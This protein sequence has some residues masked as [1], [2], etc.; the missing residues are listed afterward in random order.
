MPVQ[1]LRISTQPWENYCGGLDH[2]EIVGLVQEFE[3]I[4]CKNGID[5]MSIG[6]VKDL[7]F[8]DLIPEIIKSTSHIS[9]SVTIGDYKKGINRKAISKA[10]QVIID[11]SKK[12]DRGYGN[13]RFAAISNCPPDIPF[14]PASYHRGK[15]CF[16]IALEGSALVMSAFSKAKSVIRAEEELRS[17]FESEIKKIERSA[18]II[19]R[20]IKILFKGI[21]VSPAPSLEKKESLAFAFEKLNVGK[22]GTPGTLAISSIITKVLKSLHVKKCGYSGLMFPILEDYGLAQR[23]SE[24]CVNINTI[25]V[26][27][28]ICGTG[29]DCIPLPGNISIERIRAILLDVAVLSV[30]LNKPLSARLF[31]VSGRRAGEMTDFRSPYLVDCRIRK[32]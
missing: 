31:P 19:E 5:F 27:S 3:D 10:A 15:T 26:C 11:I 32:I 14:F 16:T 23:Y 13:F 17:I 25:L 18:R 6:T 21:D 29:L 24:G 4:S 8:A 9:T 7:R 22:F 1:S 30:K 20:Q 12:T 28:S 2:K